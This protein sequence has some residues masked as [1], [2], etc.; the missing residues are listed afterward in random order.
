MRICLLSKYPPI[1]G[2][3]SARTYWL[4]C[5]FAERGVET[6]VVTNANCVEKEYR[7]NDTSVDSSS[8]LHVHFIDSTLPW[9]IPDSQ[10]Y[11]PRLLERILQIIKES[12]IDLIDTGYLIPYGIVGYLVFKITG[13]PYVLRHGGSDLEKFFRKDV[14]GNLLKEVII[15]AAAIITDNQNK[16]TFQNLNSNIFTIPRYIP[17][18]R[19]FKPSLLPHAKPTFAYIGKIN[20]HWRHKSLHR[21]VDIFQ[22]LNGD[23][24]LLF[25]GQ[26]KGL[27]DF[28]K[29][30]NGYSLMN[31][32]FRQFVHPANMPSLLDE[33]DFLIYFNKDN[34]IKDFTNIF[35]EALWSGAQVLTDSI[36]DLDIY[37]E[38]INFP[39]SQIIKLPID[40]LV[41]TKSTVLGL[42]KP[43][44]KPQK[45]SCEL[46]YDFDKYM[47]ANISAY[48]AI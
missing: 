37:S 41:M 7:I 38:Y 45:Y 2:G 9:H 48:R 35:C 39:D 43:W 29:F 30:V 21:I 24:R 18:E 12:R 47:D 36:M 17:D 33:I 15:N 11:V 19:Y 20:Y 27:N 10:L 16:K 28:S 26:G 42:I 25:V 3:I 1:Q 40:D 46:K 8:N 5:G 6:H 4:T 13:I 32:Q 14:L 34:P 44:K 22:D 23:Y 31:T